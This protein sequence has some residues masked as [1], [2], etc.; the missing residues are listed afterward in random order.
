MFA[1]AASVGSSFEPG[2]QPRKTIDQAIATGLISAV[3]LSAVTVTQSGIESVGRGLTRGRS[4]NAS[5]LARLLFSVGTNVVV[6]AAA[7]GLARALPP[8]EAEKSRRGLLRT[9]AHGTARVATVGAALSTAIGT[10]DLLAESAPQT[11]WVSRIPVALPA[12]IAI[13]AWKIHRVHT[14]AAEAHDTTIADV[15]TRN[16]VGIAIGVGAGVLTLQAGERVIAHGVARGLARIAPA[17]D[18]VSNPIGHVVSLAVLGAGMYAGYEYAVRRVENGAAAVEPAYDSPPTSP[19]VSGGPGSPVSFESLSREGRRFVNMTLTQ[20][21]ISTVMGEPAVAD[22]IRLFVGLDSASLMEDR[23][24]LLLDEMVRTKAFERKVVCFVSPTGSGYINYVMAESLEY[25]TRGDCA[26]VTMQYSLLPSS[27]SLTRTSL[28]VDQ[29]RSIMHAISGYMRGMD[30]AKRPRLVAFGES[31]GALTMQDIWAHRSVEAMERDFIHSSLYVGTPS[32]TQFAHHW[33]IS[34]EKID[35]QGKLIELDNFGD[36]LDLPA[37]RQQVI[38][39]VLVSH[40]D[41]PIPKF[42]T[43][44]LM[45]RPWWLGPADLRPPRVPRSAEWAP[46]TTF[47]LTAIDLLNAMEVVPG[48]FGR[49]GHD[50]REDIP[51]FVSQAYDLPITADQLLRMERA[52]RERELVWAQKRVVTEQ[53]ARAREAVMREIK[54]WNVNGSGSDN[55]DEML[56]RVLA[57]A[58]SS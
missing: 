49:R 9:A 3:T 54:T 8:Q 44:L 40:Y 32:A 30:P 6:G 29:N 39:H 23:V 35:P 14:K 50:Y 2:L 46:W 33:R 27:M 25:L 57:S 37:D 13:S 42:G 22:P 31:L 36:F 11:R 1:A 15:S 7:Y 17:Y 26:I 47:V 41:D 51:R 16:S 34:P 28:A 58:P 55:A 5:A 43:N 52:L 18:V 21:E 19:L 48:T 53:V 10:I 38:R 56:R 12:G 45:R 24:D 20:D 4:D